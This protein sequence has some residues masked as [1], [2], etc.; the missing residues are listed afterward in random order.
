[1]DGAIVQMAETMEKME[2]ERNSKS[3]REKELS[4]TL[5]GFSDIMYNMT[6]E[7]QALKE[8]N[9]QLKKSV[10]SLKKK[11]QGPQNVLHKDVTQMKQDISDIKAILGCDGAAPKSANFSIK[12]HFF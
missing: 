1:M 5:K 4:Q 12:S 8:S 9:A 3:A 11:P 7:F 2:N 10:E 6:T